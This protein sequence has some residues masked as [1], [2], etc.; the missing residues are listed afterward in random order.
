M[1]GLASSLSVRS[2][3]LLSCSR[4]PCAR[5]A[6][7]ARWRYGFC[8]MRTSER[9]ETAA[10]RLNDERFELG[11]SESFCSHRALRAAT[12]AA[13]TG[14]D[15]C[16]GTLLQGLLEGLLEGLPSVRMRRRAVLTRRSAGSST[17]LG[18]A[19]ALSGTHM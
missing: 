12:A 15:G 3:S 8:S 2:G 19:G 11:L 16:F 10:P 14:E 18:A 13:S 6:P 7:R 9:R 17:S 1:N 5:K 4:L